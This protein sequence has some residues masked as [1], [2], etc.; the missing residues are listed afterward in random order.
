LSS[1]RER[2]RLGDIVENGDA[3]AEYVR[4]LDLTAFAS[5]RMRIDA[6]ERCLERIIEAIAKIGAERM[7]AIA[8]DVPYREV[9]GLGNRLRHSYDLL[10]VRIIWETATVSVPALR[11]S[12][13]QAISSDEPG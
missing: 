13:A 4:G 7:A 1:R 10:D 5:D 2:L 9:R 8:P 12:C 6:V 3:I 11:R